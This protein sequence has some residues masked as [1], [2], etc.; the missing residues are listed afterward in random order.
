MLQDAGSY[1]V[2]AFCVETCKDAHKLVAAWTNAG[3]ASATMD[4][5]AVGA[6]THARRGSGAILVITYGVLKRLC[7]AGIGEK[8]QRSLAEADAYK[9]LTQGAGL[10]I[11]DEAHQIRNHSTLVRYPSLARSV[12]GLGLPRLCFP[13]FKTTAPCQTLARALSTWTL[14]IL[15]TT[16]KPCIAVHAIQHW[17]RR[18]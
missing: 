14:L 9:A 6:A 7:D 2:A 12:A 13:F 1:D 11:A 16:G 18:P 3:R 8:A 5:T 10:V 4:S 15:S 17:Q